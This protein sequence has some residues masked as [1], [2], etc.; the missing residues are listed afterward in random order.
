M[1]EYQMISL[2]GRKNIPRGILEPRASSLGKK[3]K[4]ERNLKA[5]EP[6]PSKNKKIPRGTLELR[7]SSLGKKKNFERNLRAKEPHPSK[8]KKYREEP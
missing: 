1:V 3:K 6:H 7:A 5:K 2:R 8:N 4:F